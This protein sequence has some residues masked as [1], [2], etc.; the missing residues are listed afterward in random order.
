MSNHNYAILLAGGQGS[1]FWPQSRTLEPKQF[2]SL[3]EN[4]S[5]FAQTVKRIRPLIQAKN[6]FVVTSDLYRAQI[7][8]FISPFNIP[9]ENIICEPT[10]KNTAPSIGLAVRLISLRDQ[11]A[12]VCV[13]PCDHMINH[14]E[15]FIRALDKALR[16]CD[17]SLVVFGIPPYRPATGY[18][19]I[20][21]KNQKSKIKNFSQVE[22]FL[23]K[24]DL[25][26]AKKFVKDKRY[27]WNSGIFVGSCSKFLSD[28]KAHLPSTYRQLE[29]INEPADIKPAWD[30]INAISFDYGILENSH[31]LLML[32]ADNLGW[33][34][35]GSWQAWDEIISKDKEGNALIG[36]VINL[37]SRNVTVL[38]KNHLI[39][40]IGLDNL[41]VVDTPDALLITKKDKSEEV[42]KIVDI[43][44]ANKRQEH[45]FHRT[46]KR[47]WG[48]YTVLDVGGGFKIKLVEVKPGCS[49]SL[50]LHK[51]RSEHWVVV[52]GKARIV[53]GKKSYCVNSNESTFIPVSC[54]HRLTNVGS[55]TLK[56]VEVQTGDYLE[57]DDIVRLKDDFGRSDIC[58]K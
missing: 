15:R 19:Y 53:K 35:L 55:C 24:P 21:I 47:P 7:A 11:D 23:E 14:K 48:S 6:I 5:L 44:K 32:K 25:P 38:G 9:P 30:K 42:K 17:D 40:T 52:E 54:I 26:K 36:D 41:I 13:L 22:K 37:G 50:Q 31:S 43:L 49:L 27:F 33:S 45:Y 1:R 3:H 20:K 2:L 58:K 16:L 28:F 51:K 10:P 46:V 39:A 56:I 18:G 57:E 8:E 34:D 12:R 29:K 4:D